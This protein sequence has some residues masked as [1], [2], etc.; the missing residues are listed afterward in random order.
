PIHEAGEHVLGQMTLADSSTTPKAISPVVA[1]R[2][3]LW[4]HGTQALRNRH[5]AKTSP[6]PKKGGLCHSVNS[7]F[8]SP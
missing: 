3:K 8:G 4:G 7:D 2:W 6:Q 1:H 5:S